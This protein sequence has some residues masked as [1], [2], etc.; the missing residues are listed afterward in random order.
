MNAGLILD[1][2][3]AA[4]VR[5]LFN[6]MGAVHALSMRLDAMKVGRVTAS[7]PIGEAVTQQ[8]GTVHAGLTAALADTAGG[9]A[10]ATL[11]PVEDN[12]LAVEFK[13]NLLA[14][15]FGD[16]LRADASVVR[17]GRTITV[18]EIDV[19]AETAGKPDRHVA[20]MQQTVIRVPPRAG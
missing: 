9:L 19:F 14:T 13:I 11:A 8:N 10:A 15:A 17:G 5:A 2:A 12:V 20:R 4:R 3:K 6:S 18:C 7:M 1:A 16:R